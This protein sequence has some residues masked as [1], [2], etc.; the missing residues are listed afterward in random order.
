MRSAS[1][2]VGSLIFVGFPHSAQINS[3]KDTG[4]A[5][6]MVN[7]PRTARFG[8]RSDFQ[9]RA[10]GTTA[11]SRALRLKKVRVTFCYTIPPDYLVLWRGS[12]GR[13][14]PVIV[15]LPPLFFVLLVAAR[16]LRSRPL[17]C[18]PARG[19]NHDLRRTRR[20]DSATNGG[21]M[22]IKLGWLLMCWK[23]EPRAHVGVAWARHTAKLGASFRSMLKRRTRVVCLCL[24]GKSL[25]CST[26]SKAHDLPTTALGLMSSVVETVLFGPALCV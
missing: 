21:A 11:V 12:L 19:Q 1:D 9:R 10:T 14:F 17:C 8:G 25:T 4:G 26:A 3:N 23:A 22:R 7:V 16:V 18:A 13:K 5:R 24:W 6:W 15:K 20:A 2:R